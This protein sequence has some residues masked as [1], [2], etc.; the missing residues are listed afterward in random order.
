[1]KIYC[2]RTDCEHNAGGKCCLGGIAIG[3]DLRCHSYV[4]SRTKEEVDTFERSVENFNS[5]EEYPTEYKYF[6]YNSKNE[7][8]SDGY[9]NLNTAIKEAKKRGCHH[10]E[11]HKY[12]YDTD[13]G[14]KMYP[15]DVPVTVW[16]NSKVV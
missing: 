12:Y 13:R 3:K 16:I 15:D 2:G 6:L 5:E 10:V 14:N 11:I 8:V 1:M 4:I 7:C 9:D